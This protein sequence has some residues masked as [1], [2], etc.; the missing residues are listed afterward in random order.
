MIDRVNE[1]MVDFMV[2]D[3]LILFCQIYCMQGYMELDVKIR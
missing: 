3:E 1:K 2:F